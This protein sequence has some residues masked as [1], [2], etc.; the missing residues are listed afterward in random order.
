[1]SGSPRSQRRICFTVSHPEVDHI[2]VL[3]QLE[4]SAL[5]IGT[6]WNSFSHEKKFYSIVYPRPTNV[7][8]ASKK[9]WGPLL[10]VGMGNGVCC[11]DLG[12]EGSNLKTEAIE[13]QLK[14]RFPRAISHLAATVY[15]GCGNGHT[16]H[17]LEK[18]KKLKSLFFARSLLKTSPV[19]SQLFP[20]AWFMMGVSLLGQYLGTCL[21]P[22]ITK[23]RWVNAVPHF[24]L[25]HLDSVGQ[26]SDRF[27][28]THY[29]C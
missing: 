3:L 4:W 12:N 16:S 26:E 15:E 9:Q 17:W 10:R 6:V 8:L 23:H 29:C 27:S 20:V 18:S 11:A 21:L 5:N 24:L 25:V 1:M 19:W 28:G 22:P 14:N 2:K 13:K 7:K